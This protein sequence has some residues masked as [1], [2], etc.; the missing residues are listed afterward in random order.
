[1]KAHIRAIVKFLKRNYA[2]T[3]IRT[4]TVGSGNTRIVYTFG[5]EDHIII[6]P[7]TPSDNRALNNV[8]ADINRTL[9][10]PPLAAPKVRSTLEEMTEEAQR[11]AD[12][13]LPMP[14]APDLTQENQ[15]MEEEH[16]NTLPPPLKTF[17]GRVA[18]Y[19][20]N[21]I[22]VV[23]P[24]DAMAAFEHEGCVSMVSF[25]N[26]WLVL[27]AD[28]LGRSRF[29]PHNASNG[30]VATFAGNATTEEWPIFGRTPVNMF[31]RKGRIETRIDMSTIR[32]MQQQHKTAPA[33]EPQPHA[34]EPPPAPKPP[35]PPPLELKPIT[36]DNA[37]LRSVIV[38]INDIEARSAYK[39]KRVNDVWVWASYVTADGN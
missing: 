34:V 4:T 8:L 15:A 21:S 3:N 26:N 18:H 38:N 2:A 24:I 7:S 30:F 6:A 22:H 28:S 20:G 9:G 33:P 37:Y 39:L 32:P 5:G 10:A 23:L 35:P 29:R 14:V 36:I 12:A 11:R 13:G 25:D 16:H 19:P 31:I 1:M 17:T 27:N